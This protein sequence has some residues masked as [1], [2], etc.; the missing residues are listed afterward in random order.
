[1]ADDAKDDNNAPTGAWGS[2]WSALQFL[3]KLAATLIAALALIGFFVPPLGK[4]VSVVSAWR[5]GA[6]GYVY[7]GVGANGAPS[8]GGQL[9]VLRPGP[10]NF[11]DINWGE[12]LQAVSSH[13][14]R[15]TPSLTS[16]AMFELN[17]GD[18]VVVLGKDN[19][20]KDSARLG[21]AA[22]GGWLYVAT[23]ACG[24]FK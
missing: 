18:C 19:E 12:R 15:E 9:F 5:F 11:G 4:L 7:Y 14:F 3:T 16:R 8:G 13:Q 2:I 1:M 21:E 20:I 24:L 23:I 10:V 17:K 22:S 6:S